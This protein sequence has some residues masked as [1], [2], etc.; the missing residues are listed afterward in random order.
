[1]RKSLVIIVGCFLGIAVFGQVNR[2]NENTSV[3]DSTRR[4]RILGDTIKATYSAL[5]TQYTL[6][7]YIK[8]NELKFFHPDTI[9]DNFHRFTDLDR[10]ENLIQNLGN[11]GTAFRPL[12]YQPNFTIGNRSGY[13]SFDEFYTGPDKVRYYDTRSPYSDVMAHFGGGGRART[14]VKFTFNDS[15][16]FNIALD[17]KSIRADK[18]LAFLQRGDR[19]VEGTD[20]NIAGYVR[21]EKI[22]KYLM[23]FNMTQMKHDVT[24]QGGIVPPDVDPDTEA[25]L[26]AY[27]DA[28]VVLTDA[29]SLEKRGGLHL[30]HQYQLDSAFQVYHQFDFYEQ[31]VRYTDGYNVGTIDS[32]IYEAQEGN[33]SGQ[34]SNRTTFREFKNEGGIKGKTSKFAYSAY[35]RLRNTSYD[36]VLINGK[37]RE[38]EH[39]LGGTLRQQI[40]KKVFLSASGEFLLDGNYFLKGDFTSDLFDVSF[41]R[42]ESKPSFLIRRYEGEQFSW[43]NNFQNEKSDNLI[44]QLKLN[45]SRLSFRPGMRFQRITNYIHYNQQKLAAQAGDDILLLSPSIALDWQLTGSLF[46]KNNV[47]YAT[48]SGGASNLYRIPKIMANSQLAIKNVLFDG[49]MILHTGLDLHFRSSY[50]PLDYNPVNQQFFLQD[51]FTA[52]SFLR[53]DFFLNFKVQNFHLQFKLEHFNQGIEELTS[54]GGYFLTPYYTGGRRTLSLGL[55]WS[56]Y[57]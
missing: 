29:R 13:S 5:T 27:R 49:K 6:E 22:Q 40:S 17:Y 46:W 33:A 19:N 41:S 57:D 1:M 14:E 39:Y 37:I 45:T 8:N 7:K 2:G 23:L 16:R 4:N 20:W 30:Y 44:G 31:L 51:D 28:N 47:Y 38:T 53:A 25:S 15:T 3:Q 21:P 32:L 52:D 43:T 56:F 55:R 12:F 34:I 36:N 48:V 35:Y 26:F 54:P 50:K 10:N 11:L 42:L 24:E 9:P 18:Q